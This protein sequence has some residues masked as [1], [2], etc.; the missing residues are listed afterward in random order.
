M[1]KDKNSK[2]LIFLVFFNDLLFFFMEH[3]Q[4]L[5]HVCFPESSFWKIT[6]Q[7]SLCLFAIRKVGEWKTLS[8][9]RKALFSQRKI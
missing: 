9:Q 4:T 8:G 3:Q 5:G 2:K 6:F 7:T 1:M